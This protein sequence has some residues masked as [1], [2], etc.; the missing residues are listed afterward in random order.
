MADLG[1]LVGGFV[2]GVA[3]VTGSAVI[4]ALL[5]RWDAPT[6]PSVSGQDDDEL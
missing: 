3:F 6:A 5:T 1:S 4:A 2:L